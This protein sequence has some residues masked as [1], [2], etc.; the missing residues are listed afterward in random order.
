MVQRYYVYQIKLS[1]KSPALRV[2][3][4]LAKSK[5]AV[6]LAVKLAAKMAITSFLQQVASQ[7]WCLNSWFLGMRNP[8]KS[9]DF[10]HGY[11]GHVNS[12]SVQHRFLGMRNATKLLDFRHG[13]RGRVN[14]R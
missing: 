14:S 1:Q 7:N 12:I 13:D 6:K 3:Q 2:M 11:C 4:N 10:S 5:M 8:T 9:V